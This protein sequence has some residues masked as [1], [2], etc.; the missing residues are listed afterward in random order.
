MVVEFNN[1]DSFYR[2]GALVGVKYSMLNYYRKTDK[3]QLQYLTFV[4]QVT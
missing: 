3:D 1:I 4:I 2:R